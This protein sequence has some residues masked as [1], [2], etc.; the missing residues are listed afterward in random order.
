MKYHAILF[1]LDGTLLDTL[2]DIAD[3]MNEALKKHG[4]PGYPAESYKKFVG[5]GLELLVRRVLP[6]NIDADSMFRLL[7]KQMQDEYSTR[8]RVNTRLYPGIRQML[9]CLTEKGLRLSILSNKPDDF[10]QKIYAHYLGKWNF[11]IV[12][13]AGDALPRKPDPAAALWIAE[14]MRL[15]P[16]EFVYL[17]DSSTDMKTAVAAGMRPIGALWGF[18]E[19]DELLESG[20]ERLIARPEEMLEVLKA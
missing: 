1:D 18:R 15:A 16:A 13:G 6:E 5:G 20:A 19:A 9:D 7:M 17:G 4:L 8:W 11:E 3:S 2:Q 10:T 14:R 12:R